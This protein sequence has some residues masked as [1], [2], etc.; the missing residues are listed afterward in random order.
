MSVRGAV[1]MSC[2]L[3]SVLSGC[4]DL[5]RAK[6]RHEDGMNRDSAVVDLLAVKADIK[7]WESSLAELAPPEFV[8]GVT[9]GPEMA[10]LSC[11][12]RTY[13]LTGATGVAIEQEFDVEGYFSAVETRF[14]SDADVETS[15]ERSRWGDERLIISREDGAVFSISHFPDSGKMHIASDSAC[16][17]IDADQAPHG[18][19]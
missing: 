6:A 14:S 19:V 15:R 10:L 9:Q 18:S 16:Y 11:T 3:L 17:L 8:D 4:A 1:F 7:E 12:E 5:D 13:R 2:V